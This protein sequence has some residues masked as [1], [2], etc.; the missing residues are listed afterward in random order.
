MNILFPEGGW[1]EGGGGGYRTYSIFCGIAMEQA[2]LLVKSG[3]KHWFLT[4]F[5]ESAYV[6]V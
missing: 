1:G 2:V 6:R 3:A 5:G 4:L